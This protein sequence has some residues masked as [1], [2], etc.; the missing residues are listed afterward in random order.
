MLLQMNPINTTPNPEAF[1]TAFAAHDISF[2][3]YH[4]ASTA[5][6]DP[7]SAVYRWN[8]FNKALVD[9]FFAPQK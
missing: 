9:H 4:Y 2:N 7:N 6:A 8:L 5:N 1:S 3:N